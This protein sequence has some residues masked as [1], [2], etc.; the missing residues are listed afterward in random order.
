V[1]ARLVALSGTM[2]RLILDRDT[3]VDIVDGRT[4]IESFIFIHL[5]G[6]EGRKPQLPFPLKRPSTLSAARKHAPQGGD[7]TP[8][9]LTYLE[10][11]GLLK[12]IKSVNKVEQYSPTAGIKLADS[13]GPPRANTNNL[14]SFWAKFTS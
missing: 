8:T 7:K 1:G 2:P 14:L 3:Q 13:H 10:L 5:L 9:Y 12:K 4:L 11:F 6:N